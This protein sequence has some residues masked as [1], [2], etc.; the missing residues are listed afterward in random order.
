MG[1]W[2]AIWK[3]AIL[4]TV[5][6]LTEFLPVSSSGHLT[7]LQQILG[8]DLGGAGMTFVNILLHFGT[9]LAV[10]FVFRKDILA[11]F[12]KPFKTLLMLIAATVPAGVVGLLFD[13]KIEALFDPASNAAWLCWLAVFFAL[14][15]FV[16][17]LTEFVSSRRKKVS[18]LGW[19][20][21]VP[22]GLAQAVA[23]FPGVSRSGSTIAAGVIS[24]AK[25][26]DVAKFSFL[27]SIP[28][29]LGS[30]AVEVY[31]VLKPDEGVTIAI[32][33]SGIIGMV[34]GVGFSAAAGFFAI[35]IMLKVIG[36]GNYKWFSL[37]LVILSLVCFWLNV[38][39]VL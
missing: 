25:R 4:G 10:V 5:Q 16:L 7:L 33:T 20:H 23:L 34:V 38:L 18:P 35:K 26:D 15:A 36:K 21:S 24:G 19:K 2:E 39:G 27:M 28:V 14:T 3:S 11:L 6:G 9:L 1:I 8:Y 31:H 29:I 17:L 30:L 32:G 12:K 13:D 37:Y 22:M